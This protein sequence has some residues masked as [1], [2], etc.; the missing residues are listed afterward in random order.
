LIALLASAG[1]PLRKLC[2]NHPRI[3]EAIPTSAPEI[4]FPRQLD[5][6]DK[7]NILVLCFHPTLDKFTFANSKQSVALTE[8][9]SK[10][11]VAA[12]V[13]TIFYPLQLI[14]PSVILYNIFL[15]E[16]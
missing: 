2:S 1:F 11:K 7:V 3:L 9:V 15:Q 10:L 6:E 16:L 5:G 12:V 13:A 4:V 8:D 14:S